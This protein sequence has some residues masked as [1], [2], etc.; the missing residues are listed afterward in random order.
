MGVGLKPIYIAM[1]LEE[2]KSIRLEIMEERV[3]PGTQKALWSE[4]GVEDC[5]FSGTFNMCEH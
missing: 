5:L 3:K 2:A 1:S 4:D